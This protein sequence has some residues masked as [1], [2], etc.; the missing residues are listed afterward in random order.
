M[1]SN[2]NV[3]EFRPKFEGSF[4]RYYYYAASNSWQVFDRAG[5]K[6]T[7]GVS[8]ES[9]DH[10]GAVG[11][12]KS[13]LPEFGF[14]PSTEFPD[15]SA[16]ANPWNTGRSAGGSSGGSAALVAAGVVPIAHGQDGG[17]SVRIP[18]ACNGLVGLKPT[19]HPR[20]GESSL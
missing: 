20:L 11:L 1:S 5:N 12:G 3:Y 16:T 18:A 15:G 4:N 14:T 13:T 2:A 10:M 7:Y 8:T 6:S 17:G 19:R 9:L